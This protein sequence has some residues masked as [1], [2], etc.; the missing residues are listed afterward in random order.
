MDISHYTKIKTKICGV[1]TQQISKEAEKQ[2]NNFNPEDH[3]VFLHHCI[4]S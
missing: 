4:A 3:T 2:V 1:E